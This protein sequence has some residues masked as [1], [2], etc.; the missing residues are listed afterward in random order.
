MAVAYED[1]ITG[2]QTLGG[3]QQPVDIVID[4]CLCS[5]ID[6]NFKSYK[7]ILTLF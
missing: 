4:T 7:G 1:G 2:V 5:D 3:S 6:K